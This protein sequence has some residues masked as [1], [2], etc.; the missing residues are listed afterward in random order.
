MGLAERGWSVAGRG[1]LLQIG[2][3]DPRALWWRLYGAGV[4]IA[5][6]GLM[7]TSTPMEERTIELVLTAFERVASESR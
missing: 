5:G 2:S 3:Q 7:C 6:N 4:L 1:S